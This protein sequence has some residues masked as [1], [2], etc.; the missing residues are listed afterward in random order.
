MPHQLTCLRVE[1]A[2]SAA[3]SSSSEPELLESR[4]IAPRRRQRGSIIPTESVLASLVF[5]GRASAS[6]IVRKRVVFELP[7]H[8]LSRR[9]PLKCS[10]GQK[11]W[12][13]S[14]LI[15]LSSRAYWKPS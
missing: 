13:L 4:K 10:Q 14:F 8:A 6:S 9:I 7:I 2:I 3:F 15:P 1:T 11:Q 5:S 12:K